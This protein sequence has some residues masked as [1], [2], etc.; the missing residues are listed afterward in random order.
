[1]IVVPKEAKCQVFLTSTYPGFVFFELG[2]IAVT[3]A[4]TLTLPIHNPVEGDV[5]PEPE[6][7]DYLTIGIGADPTAWKH[8]AAPNEGVWT[9]GVE[10]GKFVFKAAGTIPGLNDIGA[11][12]DTVA[13]G[14]LLMIDEHPD[15]SG[16][17][18]LVRLEVADNRVVAG[19]VVVETG[20]SGYRPIPD[21]VY[22]EHPKAK[23]VE[24]L[25]RTFGSLDTSGN[26]LSGGFEQASVTGAG[27]VT[28]GVALIYSPASKRLY[29]APAHTRAFYEGLAPMASAE[30]VPSTP[31]VIPSGHGV[32]NS[33]A[34]RYPTVL[35]DFSIG[36]GA[37]ENV[38]LVL[39]KD[40][41]Q[42]KEFPTAST[43]F[44]SFS[45]ID[46]VTLGNHTY[47]VRWKRPGAAVNAKVEFSRLLIATLPS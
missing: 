18:R 22:L 34:F 4:P 7:F 8:V 45:Y 42:V 10:A 3:K 30:A 17:Y 6:P 38:I 29:K 15:D 31:G 14:G 20:E 46:T 13:G 19:Y 36:Y 28:D 33:I 26:E 1:V 25:C 41:V 27:A 16:E 11:S 9:V 21:D 2:E 44:N 5:T 12:E 43:T 35:I 39:Y 47:D 32:G 24:L 40:G 37:V 23:F